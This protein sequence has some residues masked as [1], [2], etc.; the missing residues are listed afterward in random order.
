MPYALKV[1]WDGSCC[2]GR[3]SMSAVLLRPEH[4]SDTTVINEWK[5][6]AAPLSWYWLSCW[7]YLCAGMLYLSESLMFEEHAIYPGEWVESLVWM[8]CSF[9]CTCIA[10]DWAVSR[11]F[12]WEAS[13]LRLLARWHVA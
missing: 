9:I 8:L 5:E 2:H 4:L 7:A 3:R 6:A 11:S 10:S 13:R 12:P 1:S